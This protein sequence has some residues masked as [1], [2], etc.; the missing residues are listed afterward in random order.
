MSTR[1]QT[2]VRI[3]AL[4]SIADQPDVMGWLREGL[5]NGTAG[6]AS[7]A[8]DH[9]YGPPPSYDE[10]EALNAWSVFMDE[11]I[12]EVL[13]QVAQLLD[14]AIARRLPWEWPTP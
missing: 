13:P 11:A 1:T 2:P 4:P 8:F 6:V 5:E 10:P 3:E 9:A 14:A 7:Q 12:E